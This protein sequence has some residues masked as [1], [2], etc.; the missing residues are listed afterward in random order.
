[1]TYT[2]TVRRGFIAQA[3]RNRQQQ[4]RFSRP[5]AT[6]TEHLLGPKTTC[7]RCRSEQQ[8]KKPPQPEKQEDGSENTAETGT[9]VALKDPKKL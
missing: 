9:D 2:R 3:H 5:A 8:E 4:Q 1:M 7:T 6:E